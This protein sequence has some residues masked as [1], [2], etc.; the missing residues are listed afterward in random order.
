VPKFHAVPQWTVTLVAQVNDGGV[1]STTV[2]VC[3]QTAMLLQLSITCHV[4]VTLSNWL[5]A[6]RVFVTVPVITGARLPLQP[7]EVTAGA[8]KFH[9]SPM[10]HRSIRG[11]H[12]RDM[13]RGAEWKRS[14]CS[15]QHFH[16]HPWRATCAWLGS[17]A[18]TTRW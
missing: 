5:E 10:F 8:S 9:G 17:P 16:G 13:R 1:V 6:T 12:E 18:R 2:T 14:G 11:T 7:S 4:R 3:E 15:Q